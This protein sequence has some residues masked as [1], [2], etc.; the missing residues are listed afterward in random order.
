MSSSIAGAS[1]TGQV[2]ERYT[3][4]SKLLQAPV[5]ILLRVLQLSGAIS[6]ISAQRPSCTWFDQVSSSNNSINTLFLERVE[7]TSGDTNSFAAG[8]IITFTSAPALMSKRT[9]KI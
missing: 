9:S 4:S 8:V 5:A 1:M 2:A 6:I 3:A 7:S